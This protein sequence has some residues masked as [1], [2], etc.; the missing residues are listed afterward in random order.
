MLGGLVAS[1]FLI[2]GA[3]LAGFRRRQHNQPEETMTKAKSKTK[4]EPKPEPTKA[5]KTTLNISLAAKGEFESEWGTVLPYRLID[6]MIVEQVPQ[7]N[8]DGNWIVV[9]QACVTLKNG[10]GLRFSGKTAKR[11]VEGYRLW[12]A[13]KRGDLDNSYEYELA[14]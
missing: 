12:R 4:P 3:I 1:R 2:A 13:A 11:L 7:Q 14:E 6:M 9:P 10:R 5:F 8:E